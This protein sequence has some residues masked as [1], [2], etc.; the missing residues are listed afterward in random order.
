MKC[1]FPNTKQIHDVFK[2]ISMFEVNV[3]LECDSDGI[4]LFTMSNCHTIFFDVKFPSEFFAEYECV[5]PTQIGLHIPPLLTRITGSKKGDT[6]T[7]E[8]SSDTISFSKRF[9]DKTT[10]FWIKQMTIEDEALNVPSLK[11]DVTIRMKSAYAT[12]WL[13]EVLTGVTS[14][15]KLTPMKNKLLLSSVGDLAGVNHYQNIPAADIEYINYSAPRPV[16]LGN[17]H[18]TTIFKEIPKLSD[19]ME[20][21]YKNDMPFTIRATRE[22]LSFR[23]F[24]APMHLDEEMDDE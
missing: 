3:K 14:N 12:E 20:L 22:S 6:L 21:G 1:I 24:M 11:E 17:K 9:K 8:C 23:I 15:L 18:L 19:E 2:L 10:D 7:M 4:K 13:K 5:E 16:Q